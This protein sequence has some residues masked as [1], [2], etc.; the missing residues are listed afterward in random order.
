MTIWPRPLLAR[1][2]E[3]GSTR[4]FRRVSV[5]VA[6]PAVA[7]NYHDNDCSPFLLLLVLVHNNVLAAAVDVADCEAVR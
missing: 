2:E 3:G 1:M 7:D 5:A 4:H 6:A